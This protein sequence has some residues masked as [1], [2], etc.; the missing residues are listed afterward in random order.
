MKQLLQLLAE[1]LNT[2]ASELTIDTES[3]DLDTWDSVAVINLAISIESEY[4]ISLS[5]D[6]VELLRSVKAIVEIL[7][8]HEIDIT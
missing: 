3:D 1:C 2:S 6:E 8:R 7:E 5:A 4:G